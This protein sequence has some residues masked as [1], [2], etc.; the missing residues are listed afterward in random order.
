ME[1]SELGRRLLNYTVAN[2]GAEHRSYLGMSAIGHCPLK[3]YREL[4]Y[5]RVW[6]T[7]QHLYCERGYAAEQRILLK[8]AGLAGLET[9]RLPGYPF[10]AFRAALD[11]LTRQAGG[12]LGPAETFSDMGGRFVGH[13]DG[14]W[15]GDLLEIKS[16]SGYK[17]A[18]LG[19]K[20]SPNHYWQAQAYMRYGGYRRTLFVY[21]AVDT[22]QV[23]IVPVR[24]N[25]RLAEA[26]RLKAATILEAVER[27]EPPDCE[28]G[29]CG[30]GGSDQWAGDS[31]QLARSRE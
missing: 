9:T 26:V 18:Q 30:A 15:E 3:L 21:L 23:K 10:A 16:T 31:G 11:D 1:A 13:T 27:R 25:E 19:E 8:L 2:S 5:G 7:Q 6:N 22:N 29:R 4:V 24:F 28:C 20:V 12:P 14:S 17:L